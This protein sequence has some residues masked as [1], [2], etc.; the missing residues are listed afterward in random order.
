[1]SNIKNNM[2]IAKQHITGKVQQVVGAVEKKT[3]HPI[4]GAISETKGKANV[5][6][7]KLR[8]KIEESK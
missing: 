6:I 2:N 7:S 5:G 4:Q 8:A 1:M 3:G